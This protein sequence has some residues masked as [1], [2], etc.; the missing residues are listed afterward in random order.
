LLTLSA[1]CH[2]KPVLPSDSGD[3]SDEP[4]PPDE[5]A[6]TA[7]D[8]PCPVPE[9]EP[10]N[11]FNEA[12][13][14]AM[15]H[16]GCGAYD[17]PGDFDVWEFDFS[18]GGWLGVTVRAEALGSYADAVLVLTAPDGSAADVRAGHETKDPI[19]LFPG[20]AGSY[21]ALLS[22][23]NIQGDAEFYFYDILATLAKPPLSWSIDEQESN[24]SYTTAQEIEDGDTL[25]AGFESSSDNDWYVIAVPAGKHT[26]RIDVDAFQHGSAGDLSL[27]L[28]DSN[29]EPLPEGC[30]LYGTCGFYHGEQGWERDPVMQYSST[31]DEELY[32]RADEAADRGGLPFWYRLTVS[33]EGA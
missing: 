18:G 33:L 14:L 3:D 24:D 6:D 25:M 1:G 31:G 27:F 30:V 19:L 2:C 17:E 23:R 29:L 21:S 26:L 22:E 4:P 32:I 12:T 5:T 9:I 16:W 20:V 7:P 8:L 13:A 28:Y 15:E 10:N 11:S